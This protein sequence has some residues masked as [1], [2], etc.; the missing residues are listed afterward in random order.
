V[1]TDA[2]D[3]QGS[4]DNPTLTRPLSAIN[5][6]IAMI[7]LSTKEW[8]ETNLDTDDIH[9]GF[10]NRNTFYLWTPTVPLYNPSEPDDLKLNQIKRQLHD[11]RTAKAGKHV[12]YAFSTEADAILKDWYEKNYH[13]EYDSEI[14]DA[15]VQRVDENMRKLALLYAVLEN[16]PDDMEIHTEQLQAAI[17]V[18]EYWEATAIA[19]FSKFGANKA[20]RAEMRIIEWLEKGDLPKRNLQPCSCR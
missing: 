6:F 17:S 15:A 14:V 13:T 20:A 12:K 11:I 8:L 2:Y 1:L 18:G 16:A 9:G 19:L 10:V 4:L 7:G 5:P 3:C